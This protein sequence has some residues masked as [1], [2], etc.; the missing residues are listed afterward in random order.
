MIMILAGEWR[1]DDGS[2]TNARPVSLL[3]G[4]RMVWLQSTTSVYAFQRAGMPYAEVPIRDY[5][6][7]LCEN[8]GPDGQPTHYIPAV[9]NQYKP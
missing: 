1:N 4:N 3:S 2:L 6:K 7:L 8:P 5:I 9:Y